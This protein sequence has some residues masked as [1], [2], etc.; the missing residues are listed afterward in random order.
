MP[1]FKLQRR[2]IVRPQISMPFVLY[3]QYVCLQSVLSHQELDIQRL[4][5]SLRLLFDSSD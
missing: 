2:D 5:V 4:E 3:D 1:Y